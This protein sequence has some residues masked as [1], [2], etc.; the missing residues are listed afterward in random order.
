MSL[1]RIQSPRLTESSV[2]AIAADQNRHVLKFLRHR[3]SFCLSSRGMWGSS[4]RRYRAIF[5]VRAHLLLI[6]SNGPYVVLGE[7]LS[8]SA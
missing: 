8:R 7:L 6:L 3:L 5:A 4:R 2:Y 1:V